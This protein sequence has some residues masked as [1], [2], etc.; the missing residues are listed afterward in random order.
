MTSK[1]LDHEDCPEEPDLVRCKMLAGGCI[2]RPTADP[3]VFSVMWTGCV[4]PGGWLPTWVK[5][6]VAWKQS[7]M[8]GMFKGVYE[9]GVQMT[10]NAL[11]VARLMGPGNPL[12]GGGVDS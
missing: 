9:E 10:A 6:M 2:V 3:D 11:T 7:L 1:S 5:D 12:F 4:D 8:I